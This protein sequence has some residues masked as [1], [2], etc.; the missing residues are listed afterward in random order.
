MVRRRPRN[1]AKGLVVDTTTTVDLSNYIPVFEIGEA[2]EEVLAQIREAS[3]F[4]ID[5]ADLIVVSA[6]CVAADAVERAMGPSGT[7]AGR[8]AVLKEFRSL[9]GELGLSPTSRGRLK[10]SEAQ[11]AVAA[12][13]AEAMTDRDNDD[14]GDGGVI[15]VDDLA[16]L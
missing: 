8:A 11:S 12:K 5:E 6:L 15:G 3:P 7:P 1:R 9:A 16:G 10:L 13:R 2:G 4:W 14:G